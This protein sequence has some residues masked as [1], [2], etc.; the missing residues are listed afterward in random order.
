MGWYVHLHVCFAAG[1]NEGVAGVAR[2]HLKSLSAVEGE[3]W[4]FL[5]DLSRRVGANPGPKGGLSLW[6]IVGNRTDAERFVEVLRPFWA[7][8]LSGAVE[9]G[10]C[11]HEHVM[12]FYEEEGSEAANAIEI[13]WDDEDSA[14]RQIVAAHHRKLPFSWR[15]Y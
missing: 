10:P 12:V 13:G 1:R 4:S 3:A 9:N 7:E 15:Q 5:D 14:T 8:L 6:G 11:S 2:R